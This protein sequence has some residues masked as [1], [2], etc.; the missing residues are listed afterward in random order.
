MSHFYGILPSHSTARKTDATARGHKSTGM[1]AEA[2]SWNG[3]IV[4]TLWHDEAENVDR[5]RVEM[6]PHQGAGNTRVIATGIVG[7]GQSILGYVPNALN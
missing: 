3:R 6:L 2:C 7:D 4:T 5:F 1:Q